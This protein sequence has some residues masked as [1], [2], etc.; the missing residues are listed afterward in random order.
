MNRTRI[1]AEHWLRRRPIAHRGLHGAGA[2][3]NSLTAYRR[4]AEAGYPIE[5]DVHLTR[6]GE[7]AVF[8]DDTLDRVCGVQGRVEDLSSAELRKLP[9]AGT[10]DTIPMLGEVLETVAGRVPLLIEIKDHKPIGRLEE[11]LASVLRSYAGE[12]AIQSFNPLILKEMY[13]HAPEFLYGQLACRDYG[14][15][16]SRVNAW[17]LRTLR[18]RFLF[19]PDF[20]S[21]ELGALPNRYV[22]AK[23]YTL[24][25]WTVTDRAG[26]QKAASLGAN[27]IFENFLPAAPAP[28]AD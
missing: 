6:D 15:S 27:I 25:V 17:I 20:V 23:K 4:A 1:P 12:F 14:A 2:A 24:L 18:S 9:L 8:H 3:E 28:P 21:Y 22:S 16:V 5:I 19:R 7:I 13:R 11:R 10:A 26:E